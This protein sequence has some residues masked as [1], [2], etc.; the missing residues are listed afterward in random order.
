MFI[1]NP[2]KFLQTGKRQYC[3]DQLFHFPTIDTYS[4]S[5]LKRRQAGNDD[6]SIRPSLMGTQPPLLGGFLVSSAGRRKRTR[7]VLLTYQKDKVYVFK[8]LSLE[9][10]TAGHTLTKKYFFLTKGNDYTV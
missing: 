10:I 2:P 9:D 7:E 1:S 3:R 6:R 8:E 5:S 4:L